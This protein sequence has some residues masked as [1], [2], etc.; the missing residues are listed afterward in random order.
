M[1]REG[2][3]SFGNC[4]FRNRQKSSPLK[5]GFGNGK[6]LRCSGEVEWTRYMAGRRQGVPGSMVAL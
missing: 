2:T 6:R 3:S 5:G 4:I 1:R